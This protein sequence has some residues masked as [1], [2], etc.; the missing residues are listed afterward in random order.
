MYPR[1]A[2]WTTLAFIA[3]CLAGCV[4]SPERAKRPQIGDAS[5]PCSFAGFSSEDGLTCKPQDLA[6]NS[7]LETAQASAEDSAL[8]SSKSVHLTIHTTSTNARDKCDEL[9]AYA[10]P[11]PDPRWTLEIESS[12]PEDHACT[13]RLPSM[14]DVPVPFWPI[15]EE[16]LLLAIGTSSEDADE[17]L[18]LMISVLE[19]MRSH[20]AEAD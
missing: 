7:R 4:V 17:L 6:Q 14:S 16:I 15:I 10:S 8:D 12:D 18:Q 5:L 11:R 3:L 1:N 2:R 9:S 19:M 20:L 13:L